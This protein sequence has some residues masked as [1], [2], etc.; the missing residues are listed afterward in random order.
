MMNPC[1]LAAPV[2]QITHRIHPGKTHQVGA[3]LI[4]VL[5]AALILSLGMLVLVGVQASSVQLAKLAQLRTEASR[6]GQSTVDRIRAN[7]QNINGYALTTAYTGNDT[8]PAAPAPNILAFCNTQD[9][10]ALSACRATITA[11]DMSQMRTEARNALP[12]GDIRIV[13]TNTAGI[14][15]VADVWLL[16]QQATTDSDTAGTIGGT[17][18]PTTINVPPLTQCLLTRVVL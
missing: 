6:V 7:P 15:A 9:P 4:E 12:L 2:Q 1:F 11:T 18:C 3:S 16:W 8:I 17:G 10:T 5:V 13:I 14:G